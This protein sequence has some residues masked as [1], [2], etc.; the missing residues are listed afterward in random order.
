[1][2]QVI[3]DRVAIKPI[4]EK[5]V[6]SGGIIIPEIAR[7]RTKQ[8]IVKYIG[9]DVKDLQ[10]GDYVYF[11]AYD[12]TLFYSDSEGYLIIMREYFVAAHRTEQVF[13][14]DIPGLYFKDREGK[15]YPAKYDMIFDLVAMAAVD[16]NWYRRTNFGKDHPIPEAVKDALF[17]TEEV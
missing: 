7:E 15:Y 11:S 2:L 1:M 5:E 16:S 13:D 6:T 3:K 9:P 14:T 4:W 17:E 8:G 12:G 10:P